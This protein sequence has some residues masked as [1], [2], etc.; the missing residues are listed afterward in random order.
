MSFEVAGKI[1]R[2]KGER[3]VFPLDSYYNIFIGLRRFVII[4]CLNKTVYFFLYG[5]RLYFCRFSK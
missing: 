2:G 5:I 4:C 3:E 1:T